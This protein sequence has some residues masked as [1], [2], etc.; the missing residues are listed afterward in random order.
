MPS[1]A[2]DVRRAIDA[3]GGRLPFDRF[4]ATALYGTHGFY[5]V[6][7]RAGR[8]GDF[9][10][11]P[12]VGPLFGTVVA[13]ALDS[14]W[15]EL[16]RPDPFTVVEAGAGPGTLARAVLAASPRCISAMRYLAVEVSAAQR[17]L[18]PT[19][20]ESREMMP[21]DSFDG[22]ILAN[23][24]LDNLPFRLFVFD[25]GWREA[26]VATDGERFVERLFDTR[27][28]PNCLA[29]SA[30]HGARVAVLDAARTW[31][32]TALSILNSGRLV[33]FDYCTTSESMAVR[34]WREWLRTFAGHQRGAHY[35]SAVGEQDVTVE[36]AIDQLP[37]PTEMSAQAEF[38]RE[39]GIDSLVE[40]GKMAWQSAA[41]SPTVAAMT[42]RSRIREAEALCDPRGLGGFSVLQW[43]R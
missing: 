14:W 22:V 20:V 2:D 29:R 34:P 38:L 8:R 18:H 6:A 35:L 41:A 5:N 12:E 40:E 21:T 15:D 31:V 9:L 10:T 4:V 39:H 43:R 1:A 11:S 28:V 13:R 32:D 33:V 19:G 25:G 7:G 24:L 36:V 37:T 27:E 16:G 26:F 30:P 42:M 3:S 23:E 17:S